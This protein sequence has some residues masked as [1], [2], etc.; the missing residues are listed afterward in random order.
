MYRF[1]PT[2]RAGG[3]KE[4]FCSSL[5]SF[6]VSLCLNDMRTYLIRS[7]EKGGRAYLSVGAS[8]LIEFPFAYLPTNSKNYSSH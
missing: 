7:L 3:K 1:F 4:V 5:S 6:F 8:V 2:A